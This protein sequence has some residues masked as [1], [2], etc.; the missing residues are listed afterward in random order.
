MP[1]VYPPDITVAITAHYKLAVIAGNGGMTGECLKCNHPRLAQRVTQTMNISYITQ[2]E[3]Q[4]LYVALELHNTEWLILLSNGQQHLLRSIQAGDWPELLACIQ[5]AK[6]KLK[7]AARCT[8]H[9]CY[10]AHGYGYW[11]HRALMVEGID[12]HVVNP[13]GKPVSRF[14][15]TQEKRMNVLNLL[16][17]LLEAVEV[18]GAVDDAIP[19][20]SHQ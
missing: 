4:H 13:G 5:D 14:N 3:N 8:V 1:S 11:L 7:C 6:S 12:S 19:A 10:E 17:E 2:P 18:D 15:P 16:K 20:L 9:S